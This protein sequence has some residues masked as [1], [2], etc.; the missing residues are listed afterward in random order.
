MAI[1][2]LKRSEIW[3]FM[4]FVRSKL[5]TF[6]PNLRGQKLQDLNI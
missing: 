4:D 5:G 1:K 6:N 3:I 2:K